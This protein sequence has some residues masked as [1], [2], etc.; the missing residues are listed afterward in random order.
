MTSFS[1]R[2]KPVVVEAFQFNKAAFDSDQTQ[3]LPLWFIAALSVGALYELNNG[4]LGIK[5]LEGD[6]VVSDGD[7]I[8]KGTADELY[9]CKPEIFVEIYE[10]VSA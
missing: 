3:T 9:P 4:N 5:T 1:Y 2:K 7:Y 8:I 10:K 6:F